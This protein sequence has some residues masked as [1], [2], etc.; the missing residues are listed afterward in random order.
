MLEPWTMSRTKAEA[1]ETI[2]SAGVPCSAVYDTVELS[3]NP[4]FE[5]RGIFQTM[6]HP[7]RGEFKMP[8]WP[9]KMSGNDVPMSAAPLLGEHSGEVLTEWLEMSDEEIAL[10]RDQGT[11]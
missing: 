11:I 9:V 1:M 2:S 10:M 8:A 7:T 5:E 4:N 3:E 6:H